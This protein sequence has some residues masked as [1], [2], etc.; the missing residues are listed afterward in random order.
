MG[1]PTVPT[2]LIAS[3]QVMIRRAGTW[4]QDRSGGKVRNMGTP[5]GPYSC[6][7][8]PVSRIALLDAMINDRDQMVARYLVTF[9]NVNPR[10]KKHDE[11]TWISEGKIVTV[12]EAETAGTADARI[13]QAH[14]EERP[15]V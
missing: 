2:D 4:T 1:W 3:D 6:S 13:W 5:E 7:F 11:L 12:V 14:V 10:L 15:A 9:T 8:K